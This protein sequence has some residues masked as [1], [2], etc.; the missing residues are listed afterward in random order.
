MNALSCSSSGPLHLRFKLDVDDWTP[1][2]S[3]SN[4]LTI[5]EAKKTHEDI[6]DI[7]KNTMFL[8][9]EEKNNAYMDQVT[10]YVAAALSVMAVVFGVLYRVKAMKKMLRGGRE[11]VSK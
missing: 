9:K 6:E 1:A 7:H 5:G 2:G 4:Y 8:N 10:R 3:D 11:I